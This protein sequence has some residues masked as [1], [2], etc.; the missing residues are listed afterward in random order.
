[1][2]FDLTRNF[3]KDLKLSWVEYPG[4]GDDGGIRFAQTG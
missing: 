1:M 4:D 3:Q 2:K